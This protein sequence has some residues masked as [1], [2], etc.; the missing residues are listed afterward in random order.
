M[1]GVRGPGSVLPPLDSFSLTGCAGDDVARLTCILE[2]SGGR[3]VLGDTLHV[4][5]Y[6]VGDAGDLD[7]IARLA[8]GQEGEVVVFTGKFDPFIFRRE[9]GVFPVEYLYSRGLKG[10]VL[11]GLDVVA[12]WEFGM[13]ARNDLRLVYL[14]MDSGLRGGF[15]PLSDLLDAGVKIGLGSGFLDGEMGACDFRGVVWAAVMNQCSVLRGMGA[16]RGVLGAVVGGWEVYGLEDG[17]L[18]GVRKIDGLEAFK[19]LYGFSRM[20]VWAGLDF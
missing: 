16:C 6:I 4:E 19:V 2:E 7:N 8:E 17:V 11:V 14:P 12:S 18:D 10:L 15:L 1:R 3:C 5:L 20:G 13:L 9:Y